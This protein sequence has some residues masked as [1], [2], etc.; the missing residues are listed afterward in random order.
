MSTTTWRDFF[1]CCKKNYQDEE[2][3]YWRDLMTSRGPELWNVRNRINDQM[4]DNQRRLALSRPR[5]KEYILFLNPK[6]LPE[7]E[8]RQG[9]DKINTSTDAQQ[10]HQQQ[11]MPLT[12]TTGNEWKHQRNVI[13]SAFSNL[14][15]LSLEAVKLINWRE[16]LFSHNMKKD[17]LDD[18]CMLKVDLKQVILE[19]SLTWLTGLF[20]GSPGKDGEKILWKEKL[21]ASC[22]NYWKQTRALFKDKLAIQDALNELETSLPWNYNNDDDGEIIAAEYGGILLALDA[23]PG[24]ARKEVTDNAVNAMIAS[25]DAVQSLVFWTLWNLSKND[26][27]WKRCRQEAISNPQQAKRD[28]VQLAMFKKLATQGK[29][30]KFKKDFSE[31]VRALVETVRVYPP[32]WT[33]PRNWSNLDKDSTSIISSKFDVLSCNRATDRV[34]S[35]DHRDDEEFYIASFGLGKRHCPAGTAGLYAAYEMIR[36]L[37][38]EVEEIRECE[39]H[40]ALNNCYLAPTLSVHGPQYFEMRKSQRIVSK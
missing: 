26:E 23:A 29:P 36:C 19:L 4:I 38:L 14:P 21:K 35:L 15:K 10:H 24:L 40:Q 33:L 9:L 1:C 8:D 5:R 25:L 16:T 17:T 2:T 22:F 18:D 3:I 11:R 28:L 6:M 30:I 31:L 13:C 7:L 34:W 20:C 32:V 39:P 37:F 27:G 12:M